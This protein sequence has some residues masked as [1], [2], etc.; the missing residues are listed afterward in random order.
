MTTTPT[1][2]TPIRGTI[3]T[4]TNPTPALPHL[5]LPYLAEVRLF[6]LCLLLGLWASYVQG[7][8]RPQGLPAGE[9]R[10]S[11]ITQG[12][13][14][15]NL[16][17]EA[18][19]KLTSGPGAPLDSSRVGGLRYF[20]FNDTFVL[21]ALFRPAAEDAPLLDFPT[22]DG[23]IK[24]Y[25]SYGQLY[26]PMA[27]SLHVLTIYEAPGLAGHPIY[28]DHLFLP[29]YDNTNGDETYGGGRYLDLSRSRFEAEDYTIDFNLAYNPWCAYGE[30]YSCP[31]PPAGNALPFAVRAGEAAFVVSSSGSSEVLSEDR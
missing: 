30:Q 22:S 9:I 31:L 26:F 6:T 27:D 4:T 8:Q 19:A 7:Q 3:G 13:A 11:V 5:P 15:T 10:E 2:T 20:P 17:S 24:Q 16:R 14:L 29:F 28:G 21:K 18:L 25:W 1:L 23:R 12:A